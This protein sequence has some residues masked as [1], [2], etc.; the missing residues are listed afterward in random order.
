MPPFPRVV[1]ILLLVVAPAAA[2]TYEVPTRYCAG[3]LVAE[4][5]ITAVTPGPQGRADYFVALYNPGT[6]P[7]EYRLQVTGDVIGRPTGMASLGAGERTTT[8]LGYSLNVPGRQP[9]RNEVL[10]QA[11]LVSCV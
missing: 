3:R 6:N 2:Q 4:K 1:P 5:F 10:A 7:V 9:M 11:V 8:R